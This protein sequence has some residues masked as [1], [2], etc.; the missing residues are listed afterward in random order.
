MT[1]DYRPVSLTSVVIKSFECLVLSHLK[2]IINP[3][4]DPLQFAYRTNC[5]V[6]DA[7]NMAHHWTIWTI[8]APMPGFSLW[9]LALRSIPSYQLGCRTD[10]SSSNY[11]MPPVGESQ[12]SCQTGGSMLRWPDMSQAAVPL[13]LVPHKAVSCLHYSAPCTPTVTSPL[14]SLSSS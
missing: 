11:L 12:T 9:I 4:L 3:Y 14:T 10:S 2:S 6:D 8:Q 1:N 7:V 13:A 5:F